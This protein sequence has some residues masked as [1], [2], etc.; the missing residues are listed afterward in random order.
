MSTWRN[1]FCPIIASVIADVRRANPGATEKEIRSG[2]TIAWKSIPL[3][4]YERRGWPYTVWLNEIARQLGKR[5]PRGRKIRTSKRVLKRITAAEA[6]EWIRKRQ[7]P[8]FQEGQVESG[9]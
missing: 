9:H 2:L 4:S 5:K 8:L 3:E 1:K 6:R 7:L